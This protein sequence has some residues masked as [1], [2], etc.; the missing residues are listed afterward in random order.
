MIPI[1]IH[2]QPDDSTCGPT[3]LHAVYRYFKDSIQLSEVIKEVPSLDEGGTLE[4]LLAC[5]ALQRGYK[6]RIYTYNMFIFDPTWIGLSNEEIILKLEEQLK[7]KKGEKFHRATHAYIEFLRLG[8][9]LRTRDL[10]KGLLRE[11]FD[12]GIP[13]LCGLSATYLYQSAR[14]M[15]DETGKS[16]YDDIQGYPM[17]HFVVLCGFVDDQKCVVVA[18]PYPD[19]PSFQNNYYEVKTTHLINSIMLGMATFDANLLAIQPPTIKPVQA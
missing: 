19:N 4:V 6:A 13:L 16:I 18:D 12:Q 7:Y 1:K 5:H 11:Y 14:E 8:G 2:T 9:E 17:G 15:S 3:S 10:N